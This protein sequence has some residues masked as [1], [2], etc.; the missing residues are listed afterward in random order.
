MNT[1]ADDCYDLLQTAN[2]SANRLSGFK[3]DVISVLRPV[4]QYGNQM[5]AMN[6]NVVTGWQDG[7]IIAA[8]IIVGGVGLKMISKKFNI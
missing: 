6:I 3:D 7:A 5:P 1:T 8:A 4:D 2:Y